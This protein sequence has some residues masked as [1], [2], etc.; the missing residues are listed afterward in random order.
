MMQVNTS[1]AGGQQIAAQNRSERV[2]NS[3]VFE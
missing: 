1:V 3:G 2:F